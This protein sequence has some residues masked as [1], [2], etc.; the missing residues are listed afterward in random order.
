[1][2]EKKIT[3]GRD[4]DGKLIRKSIYGKTKAEIEKKVFKAKQEWLEKNARTVD[5][6]ITFMAFTRRWF[7]TE[8]A[9]KSEYTKNTYR[10][11]IEKYLT[12]EFEGLYFHEIA[13]TDFQNLINDN[14][15]KPAICQQIK[16]IIQQIYDSADDA[17]I[18][19][20]K[21]PNF[22]KLSL[23][24]R[25]NEEK[26]ALSEEE[27]EALFKAD[28]D[29]R[30]KA[31][32]T[33]LYYT[34]MRREEALAL[35]PSCFD[36]KNKT[37][38]IRQTINFVTSNQTIIVDKAKNIYSLRT[39]YLPDVCLSFLKKYV[40]SCK[41][42]L[43]PNQSGENDLI[44]MSQFLTLWRRI[45]I[46]LSKICPSAMELH[47]HLFRHNYAT[48]LYYSNM[49]LKMAA[50]LLGH[51][52]TTMLNKVYAHLD[53]KKELTTLKLNSVFQ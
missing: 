28:F 9:H 18:I 12:P 47:P 32:I 33:I 50:K 36:F 4:K 37:V 39:I 16:G 26:R 49:S 8:K 14:W 19:S 24:P 22:K 43:F 29:D 52:D 40:S 38:T 13:L 27:K 44:T 31:L 6:S 45:R 11:I 53:E 42:Y 5:E 1:M 20:G 3:L 46:K 48:M 10:N 34:G 41:G 17:E 21:M 2:L 7:A 35:K 23:P 25:K 30:E 15:Q 51:S